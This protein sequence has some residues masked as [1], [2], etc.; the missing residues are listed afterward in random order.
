LFMNSSRA[1]RRIV[2]QNPFLSNMANIVHDKFAEL[3]TKITNDLAKTPYLPRVPLLG[4][5]PVLMDRR[6]EKMRVISAPHPWVEAQDQPCKCSEEIRR[7][8]TASL[9]TEF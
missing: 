1:V 7:S 8:A 2:R 9:L 3:F 4:S 6:D 5:K